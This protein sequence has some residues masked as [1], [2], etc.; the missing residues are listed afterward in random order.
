MATTE[1]PPHDMNFR[2][3]V[4]FFTIT[5]ALGWGILALLIFF[6]AQTE[7]IF[8]PMGYTNPLFILAVYSPAIAAIF[9]VWR[10]CGAAGL[11]R[12]FRRLTLWRM[13]LCWWA[14]LVIGIPAAFY[15]GAAIKGTITDPFSFSPWYTVLPALATG[16]VIGPIEELG[17]RGLALPLL[18][19]RYA[20]LWS[21]LILGPLAS[22]GIL[23]QRKPSERLV[24]RSVLCRRPGDHSHSDPHV[25]RRTGQPAHCRPL[26][27]PDERSSLARRPALGQPRFRCSCYHHRAAEPTEYAHRRRGG[28]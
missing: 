18:Q 24:L 27:L 12:F 17:W 4:P 28:N 11:K 3:L 22:A 15:L 6:P 9:L 14:F 20:P 8:G 23:S 25:Q 5:F 26:P 7:S 2:I 21:S 1:T 19:R 16:L 13:P 10:G